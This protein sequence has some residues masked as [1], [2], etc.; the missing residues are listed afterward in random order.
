[1]SA[2]KWVILV[3][4]AVLL[5]FWLVYRTRVFSGADKGKIT[6]AIGSQEWFR[7][8]N[9]IAG[10]L[11][12]ALAQ[13][14]VDRK[15]PPILFPYSEKA[16]DIWNW[17]FRMEDL[18]FDS[19]IWGMLLFVVAGF[20]LLRAM[21][22]LFE[23][24]ADFRPKWKKFQW[25]NLSVL[26]KR[27][28]FFSAL[29][30]GILLYQVGQLKFSWISIFLWG[31]SILL[32]SLIFFW[33]DRRAG[34]KLSISITRGDVIWLVAL[35]GAGLAI[36]A[37]RLDQIPSGQ[38]PDEGAFFGTA[39]LILHDANL[40]MLLGGGVY[41]F[42]AASS[43]FQAWVL[44]FFGNNIWGWRFSSVLAGVATVLP[45]YFLARALFNRKV[46]VLACWLMVTNPYFLVF[47][48]LG[49]NNSQA[50]FPV[51]LT[52]LFFTFGLQKRSYFF[53]WLAGLAA[54]LGFYTYSAAWLGL[55]AVFAAIVMMPRAWKLGTR[56]KYLLAIILSA[57]LMIALPRVV[58]SSAR[59]SSVDSIQFK[60]W[61]T[62]LVSGFYGHA[63]YGGYFSE[64][65]R[66][67]EIAGAEVF[68][69]PKLYGWLLARGVMRTWLN[70][71]SNIHYHSHFL[72]S[73]LT[74]TAGFFF[75]GSLFLAVRQRKRLQFFIPLVWISS[76]IIMLGIL[77]AY[78][79]RPTHL[80][81]IL[82]VIAL[83]EALG[84]AALI[85]TVTNGVKFRPMKIALP[86]LLLVFCALAVGGAGL[87]RYFILMP[88]AYPAGM[89]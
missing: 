76:G 49:Y 42:P 7:W 64:I 25:N 19:T 37:Y 20:F 44:R 4:A 41:T 54:G 10:V 40:S 6:E 55:I 87:Y 62:S 66:I 50:L 34:L 31:S 45:L 2:M 89:G 17:K 52:M 30:F 56:K 61:E 74:G 5:D 23:Q 79:P 21:V 75:L 69:S 48:R 11:C 73:G 81:A 28:I 9:L 86:T 3:L 38:V 57:C 26:E 32:V 47:A 22:S 16:L 72:I 14:L 15:I 35:L 18:N 29:F 84:M 85:K 59:Y 13:G 43:L 60:V 53:L 12:F 36:G 1:M 67:F 80:V 82:P 46:A 24:H 83:L 88:L 27:A 68:F 39:Q 63:M 70:L 71:F 77:A 51:T 58:Y 33:H 65:A 78:P 8:G